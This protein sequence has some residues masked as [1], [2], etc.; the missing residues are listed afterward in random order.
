ME[1]RE[2]RAFVFFCCEVFVV[3]SVVAI[4]DLSL[5]FSHFFPVFKKLRFHP[6]VFATPFS[7]LNGITR[8]GLGK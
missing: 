5:C 8:R 4:F 3:A 1:E 2:S 7:T 6:E